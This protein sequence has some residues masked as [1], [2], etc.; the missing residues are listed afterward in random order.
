LK[1]R[2][3]AEKLYEEYYATPQM[4]ECEQEGALQPVGV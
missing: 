3:K 2:Q 1:I 4:E